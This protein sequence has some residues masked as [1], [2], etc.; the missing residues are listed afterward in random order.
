MNIREKYKGK[1][2]SIFGDSIS[3]FEGYGLYN[4]P[5]YYQYEKRFESGVIL[6]E[7][8]WWHKVISYCGGHL[9][10]NNSW[11]GGWVSKWPGSEDLYPAGCSDRR[12]EELTAKGI[13]PDVII[14]FMGT[15]DWGY[16][17]CRKDLEGMEYFPN[18][19]DEMIRKIKK[20]FPM[21]E[22]WCCT[23]NEA[24]STSK[25]CTYTPILNGV[26]INFYNDIIQ[27]VCEKYC[28]RFI[29]INSHGKPYTAHDGAHPD[30]EGMKTLASLIIT[31]IE[32]E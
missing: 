22:I 11:S 10:V 5:I 32:R 29:N 19:Y 23:L 20:R 30:V 15:N 28:C 31:E 1:L 7:D 12:I 13:D 26:H 6:V 14:V 9:L 8:T 25:W 16:G 2:F 24:E 3:T 27:S 4:H 17:A 18:A 21:S